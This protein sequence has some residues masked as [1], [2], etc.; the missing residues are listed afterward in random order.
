M[1]SRSP[2]CLYKHHSYSSQRTSIFQ[3]ISS[4]KHQLLPLRRLASMAPVKQM[5][6]NID[7]VCMMCKTKPSEAAK[8]LCITCLTSWHVTCITIPPQTVAAV[9]LWECSVCT[10]R[11]VIGAPAD[12]PTPC[13][14]NF[15]LKCFGKWM[16]Q[17]KPNCPKCRYVIPSAMAR[18][19]R[20]NVLMENAIREAKVSVSVQPQGSSSQTDRPDAAFTTE[21]ARKAGLANA[22]SGRILVTVPRD[23]FGPITAE[24]DPKRNQGVLVGEYWMSRMEVRQWGVHFAHISGISGQSKTG[25]QSVVLSGVYKDDEDHGEAY[26]NKHSVYSPREGYRYDG[27]YRIERCWR[28]VGVQ[29][30]AWRPS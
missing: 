4:L 12:V 26:K 21:R 7:G 25:A 16:S 18:N 8:V 3:S 5:P 22:S 6:C 17:G 10:N 23:H 2:P 14:H 28:K 24:N 29:R 11:D 20:V 1:A 19:P 13:G 30:Y 27:I 15:C 9:L